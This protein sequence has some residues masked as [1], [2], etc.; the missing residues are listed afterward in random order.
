MY[1]M[2]SGSYL[3]LKFACYECIQSLWKHIPWQPSA[4]ALCTYKPHDRQSAA[5]KRWKCRSGTIQVYR[6]VNSTPSIKLKA[7]RT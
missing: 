2:H 4:P 3:F 7:W 1:S 6:H 5:I